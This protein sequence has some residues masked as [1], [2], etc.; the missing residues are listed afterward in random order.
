MNQKVSLSDLKGAVQ[1]ESASNASAPT[2][3]YTRNV[4]KL[5]RSYATGKR[6]D[7]V[8]RV[9]ISLDQEKNR[10]RKVSGRIFQA[11]SIA[12]AFES[13]FPDL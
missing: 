4:D 1:T 6:K 8:A 12:H 9:W 3:T 5:G 2:T 10:K 13:A 7:A 11:P